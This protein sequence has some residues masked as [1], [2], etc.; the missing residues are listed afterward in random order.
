MSQRQISTEIESLLEQVEDTVN[1]LNEKGAN[2]FKQGDYNL[3][4]S[5]LRD[6]ERVSDFRYKV[7]SLQKEW[8]DLFYRP[9]NFPQTETADNSGLNK[10]FKGIR[11]PEDAFRKPVLE[12]LVELKGSA[13]LDKILE[14]IEIRMNKSLNDYDIEPLAGS[15]HKL[16][17]HNTARWCLNTMSREGLVKSDSSSGAWLITEKGQSAFRNMMKPEPAPRNTGEEENSSYTP[18]DETEG[19]V[20]RL[21]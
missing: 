21:S 14:R 5:F 2:S 19:T 13:Q 6:A 16:R 1:E 10:Q 9:R 12:S 17:W 7:R 15:S 20:K 18:E 3:A 4:R 8:L 11:T